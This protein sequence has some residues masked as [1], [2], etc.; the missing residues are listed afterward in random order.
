MEKLWLCLKLLLAPFLPEE[1]AFFSAA[2]FT[3]S[4][5]ALSKRR[6][7]S[8]HLIKLHNEGYILDKSQKSASCYIKREWICSLGRVYSGLLAT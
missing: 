5:R 3:F 1:E 2:P 4:K 6:R 7:S 8:N